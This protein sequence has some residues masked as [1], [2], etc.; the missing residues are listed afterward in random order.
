MHTKKGNAYNISVKK[1]NAEMWESA[2]SLWGQ[3]AAEYVKKLEKKGKITLQQEKTGHFTITPN[4]AIEATADEARDVVF[5]S[6]ILGQGVVITKTFRESDFN[7]NKK[8]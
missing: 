3:K 7:L 1:D 8:H 4:I 5:G 2:D 6:D